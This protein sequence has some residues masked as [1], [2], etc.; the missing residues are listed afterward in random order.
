MRDFHTLSII[1]G[2]FTKENAWKSRIAFKRTETARQGVF[3]SIGSHHT[4][5]ERKRAKR[6][7]P[8][9]ETAFQRQQA[10]GNT[11]NRR[12]L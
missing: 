7:F 12:D 3:H 11:Q 9:Q 8:S 6:P 1:I 4:I 5:N 10:T 2:L